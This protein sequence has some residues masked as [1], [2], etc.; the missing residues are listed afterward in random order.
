MSAFADWAIASRLRG[1]RPEMP[2][3]QEQRWSSTPA[4]RV[5]FGLAD[6]IR[7]RRRSA[8]WLRPCCRSAAS[9]LRA[10]SNRCC[11]GHECPVLSNV[12]KNVT[13]L[14]RVPPKVCGTTTGAARYA[15]LQLLLENNMDEPIDIPPKK[16]ISI[17][18]W[19]LRQRR[20]LSNIG[21]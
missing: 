1:E 13:K 15:K 8:D 12:A 5:R 9:P 19:S 3:L 17:S 16:R 2:S 10:Q 11:I 7:G 18:D 6:V 4:H 14:T 21:C 20:Q